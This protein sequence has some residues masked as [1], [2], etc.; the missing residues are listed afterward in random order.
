MLRTSRLRLI[1]LIITG[2]ALLLL[3]VLYFSG[4]LAPPIP[5]APL[6]NAMQR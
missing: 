2:A 5:N 4:S 6:S 1:G 3:L